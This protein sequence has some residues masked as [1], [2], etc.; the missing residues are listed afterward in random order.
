MAPKEENVG[1][2]QHDRLI[3]QNKA[4]KEKIRQLEARL[5]GETSDDETGVRREE[6]FLAI[7][8]HEM[9]TPINVIMGLS[10]LL[11]KGDPKPD[12]LSN[13]RALHF[14]AENLLNLTNNILGFSKLH[15]EKLELQ[16]TDFDLPD[17]LSELEDSYHIM[18][19]KNNNELVFQ[20]KDP[21]P[22]VVRGDKLKLLQVLGN[23]LNNALK[24]TQ[25]GRVEL[26][27]SVKNISDKRAAVH[28][29][30][31]DNGPGI[32]EEDLRSIFGR[33]SR[34]ADSISKRVGGTGLGLY[35]V[36]RFL[37][38]MGSQ[39]DVQSKPGKGSEFSFQLTYDQV[40]NRADKAGKK[41]NTITP[42]HDVNVLIAEDLREQREVLRQF[43]SRIE[44]VRADIVRNGKEALE[45]LDDKRYD[46]IFLD[47]KM[48][49]YDGHE[50]ARNIRKRE[51][52]YFQHVPVIAL[53]ADE[54]SIDD[55]KADFT[56]ILPKPFKFAKLM[57]MIRRFALEQQERDQ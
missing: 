48:P 55:Q 54:F 23:L 49:E 57:D 56:A 1:N 19:D 46:I 2:N 31:K 24:Y 5:A 15:H 20:H 21:L 45:H 32:S 33:F 7:L 30:V 10:E 27:T 34:T 42:E 51:S 39:I 53:T 4:L 11:L 47:I 35:L 17:T 25:D 44:S 36:D 22:E 38:L 41:Q 52:E 26:I 43:F 13:L 9:R 8:S 14:S 12:Q 40:L 37:D 50:V 29:A 28:F 6:D 16:I 18:A 3:S